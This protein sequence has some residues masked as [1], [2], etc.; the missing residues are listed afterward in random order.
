MAFTL[1]DLVIDRIQIATAENSK[2]ELLYT[3]TQLSE[4]TIETTAESKE[5]KSA[6]G[7]LIK[8]FYQGKAGTFTATNAMIN[9]NVIGAASGTEKQ[10]GGASDAMIQMPKIVIVNK[11]TTTV[12]LV[13]GSNQTLVAGSV[14]VN[15]LGNN[16]AMGKAYKLGSSSASETDFILTGNKLTLPT[17]STADRFVVKFERKAQNAVKITNASDKFPGT[18]KLTLKALAVD[19]CEPDTLRS[20]YIIIPSFQVSPELSITLSTEGTLDYKGDMQISYCSADKELYT[21]VMCGEDE[22]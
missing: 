16:G 7:S 3:L 15:A 4:A 12:D 6:E 13:D 14:R 18:V 2:G 17:D 22:E 9:L 10:V 5:A 21:I 8:K 1:D 19:P 11:G 20:C